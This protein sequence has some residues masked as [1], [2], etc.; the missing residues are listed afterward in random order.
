MLLKMLRRPA[1]RADITH[2]NIDY[3]R[4][5]KSSASYLASQNVNQAHLEDH[6]GWVRGSDEAAR[7]IAVFGEANDREIA[8][9]HAVDVSASDPEPIGP[10]TCPR[11]DRETPRERPLCM[12]CGQALSPTAA[13]QADRHDA[14]LDDSFAEVATAAAEGEIDAEAVSEL[15]E[16]LSAARELIGDDPELRAAVLS[17]EDS[18][19]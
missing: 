11:C 2:T 13:E 9:A 7:Y 16:H 6:K 1:R 5:R 3:R 8:R 18:G 4:M 12:W 14:A 15:V 19:D 10:L 17:G